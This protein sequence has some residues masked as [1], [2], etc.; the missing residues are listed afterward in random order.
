MAALWNHGNP[1]SPDVEGRRKKKKRKRHRSLWSANDNVC[2]DKNLGSTTTAPTTL[3][4]LWFP[5]NY[6]AGLFLTSAAL[7]SVGAFA[8]TVILHQRLCQDPLVTSD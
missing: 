5:G 4:P 6:R 3:P 7:I 1:T 8:Q 2:S